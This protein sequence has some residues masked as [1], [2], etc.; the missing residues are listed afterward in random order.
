[1]IKTEKIEVH[2]FLCTSNF[3]GIEISLVDGDSLLVRCNAG[4]PTDWRAKKIEYDSEGEPYFKAYGN[5]Y[6]L[7]EFMRV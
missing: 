6:P 3:G 2:G 5:T 4:N 7:S 1:M